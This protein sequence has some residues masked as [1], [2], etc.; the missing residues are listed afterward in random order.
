[1]ASGKASGRG[2]HA[3]LEMGNYSKNMWRNWPASSGLACMD[4]WGHGTSE[5][6]DGGSVILKQLN[7]SDSLLFSCLESHRMR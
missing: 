7:I 1:M 6:D 2:A 3:H 4:G 5:T